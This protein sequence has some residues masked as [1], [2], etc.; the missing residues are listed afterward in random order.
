MRSLAILFAIAMCA[1]S[2]A[3]AEVTACDVLLTRDVEKAI[4]RV[5]TIQGQRLPGCAGM[6]FSLNESFCVFDAWPAG[7]DH[8]A[9]I[10]I[11]LDLPRFS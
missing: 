1:T 8:G 2:P 3:L 5:Q 9:K 11:T 10:N 4:G 7:S 6:C